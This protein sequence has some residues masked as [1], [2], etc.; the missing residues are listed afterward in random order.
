MSLMILTQNLLC[1]M[2][3]THSMGMHGVYSMDLHSGDMHCVGMRV[4][5]MCVCLL[6]ACKKHAVSSARKINFCVQL[7][8]NHWILP[9]ILGTNHQSSPIGPIWTSPA[10]W[11][12][13]WPTGRTCG[14][15]RA[16]TPGAT[17]RG[18]CDP[19]QW[20]LP[21]NQQSF[22]IKKI[23]TNQTFDPHQWFLSSNQP[24][25]TMGSWQPTNQSILVNGSC[26]Q[27]EMHVSLGSFLTS[28]SFHGAIYPYS[29]AKHLLVFPTFIYLHFFG[30]SML[31]ISPCFF[32]F[33]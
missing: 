28:L 8:K 5:K 26:F 19:L 6:W 15:G 16:P 18:S 33:P 25:L 23:A 11:G 27:S 20:F 13:R 7:R 9:I 32:H 1:R 2:K 30:L 24:V 17:R 31:H 29:K 3:T 4:C 14:G 21:T 10:G 22:L 12:R